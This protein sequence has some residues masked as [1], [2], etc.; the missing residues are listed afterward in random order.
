MKVIAFD[1]DGTLFDN[2]DILIDSYRKTVIDFTKETGIMGINFPSDEEIFSVIG[3]PPLGIF[4]GLM[5]EVDES[6]CSLMLRIFNRNLISGIESGGGTLYP[7]VKKVLNTL[8]SDR[9]RLI[10]AS[11]GALDYINAIL[12]IHGIGKYFYEPVK[13]VDEKKIHNKNEL[14]R[15]YLSEIKYN[16]AIMV[17][18]RET[19]RD[20]AFSNGIPFIGCSY[21]HAGNSE[22]EGE[23]YV[24]HNVKEIM[25]LVKDITS[26]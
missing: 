11:N 24:A 7:G 10:M 17:G 1:M 6:F 15:S 8:Y 9:Y 14:V 12:R 2:S 3:L 19:D 13:V 4:K 25:T 23:R 21:G 20:A 18:D 5:P 26:L 16:V 22:V